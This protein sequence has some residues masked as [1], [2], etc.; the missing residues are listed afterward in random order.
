MLMKV[1]RKVFLDFKGKKV[2]ASALFDTESGFTIM[3]ARKFER[4]FNTQE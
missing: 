3:S 1:R 4:F 2:E